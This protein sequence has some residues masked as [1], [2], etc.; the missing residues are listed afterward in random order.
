VA[1]VSKSFRD[2]EILEDDALSEDY[3]SDGYFQEFD[4][5]YRWLGGPTA[6]GLE[7]DL[8]EEKVVGESN[9]YGLNLDGETQ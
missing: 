5:S 3:E 2:H 6:S 7:K 8:E 4:E 1:R 9:K